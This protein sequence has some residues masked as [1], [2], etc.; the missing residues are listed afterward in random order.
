MCLLGL[1]TPSFLVDFY[2]WEVVS[3]CLSWRV[4]FCAIILFFMEAET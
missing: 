1:K 3:I 4:M 2:A